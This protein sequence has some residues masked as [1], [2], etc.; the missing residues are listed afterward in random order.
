MYDS[1]SRKVGMIVSRRVVTLLST[2]ALCRTMELSK[3]FDNNA[4]QTH[5][6]DIEDL[7]STKMIKMAGNHIIWLFNLHFI[8]T[9]NQY[10]A[11]PWE[12]KSSRMNHV[13]NFFGM[14]L[15]TT[16]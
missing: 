7:F 10:T 15:M 13:S 12:V 16:R 4:G 11:G 9:A 3:D 8:Y 6:P 5:R 2:V 14:R 1:T